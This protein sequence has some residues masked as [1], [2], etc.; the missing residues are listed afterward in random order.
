MWTEHS[1]LDF[2][3]LLILDSFKGHMVD[4]VKHHFQE[5]NIHLAVIPGGL[6]SKLQPLDVAVN[7]SF[8]AKV[9]KFT[10]FFFFNNRSY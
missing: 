2:R 8:K 7:K 1:D 3:S 9:S 4:P 6:T 10:V 5:K